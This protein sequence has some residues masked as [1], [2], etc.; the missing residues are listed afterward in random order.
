MKVWYALSA[1]AT[2]RLT[3]I[4]GS[5]IA[6]VELSPEW[7]RAHSTAIRQTLEQDPIDEEVR[8]TIE[9]RERRAESDRKAIPRAGR[10]Q[11]SRRSR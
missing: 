3:P 2:M 9:T 11:R 8:R 4:T 6:D 7:A 10:P 5:A 1:V